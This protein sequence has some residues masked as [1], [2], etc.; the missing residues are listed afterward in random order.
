ME[1][2][3]V[4][5]CRFFGNVVNKVTVERGKLGEIEEN[6]EGE[7]ESRMSSINSLVSSFQSLSVNIEKSKSSTGGE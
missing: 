4:I 2:L 3:Q 5:F 7:F 1:E 6:L